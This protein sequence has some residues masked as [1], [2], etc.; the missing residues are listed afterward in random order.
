MQDD[1]S[2]TVE[3]TQI[4]DDTTFKFQY[5]NMSTFQDDAISKSAD[6]SISTIEM[7]KFQTRNKLKCN[8][9]NFQNFKMTSSSNFKLTTR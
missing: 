1:N 2:S 8:M 7:T 6:D 3:M 9:I 4:Q 5:H